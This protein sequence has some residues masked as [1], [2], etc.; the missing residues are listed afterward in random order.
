MVISD[1]S[2]LYFICLRRFI[3][4]PYLWYFL[5][6]FFSAQFSI[7]CAD[8]TLIV[9]LFFQVLLF[10][11]PLSYPMYSPFYPLSVVE[12]FSMCQYPL[13]FS[14]FVTYLHGDSFYIQFYITVCLIFFCVHFFIPLLVLTYELVPSCISCGL[15]LPK[16]SP[17]IP[18]YTLY[19]L[20]IFKLCP[21]F[22]P[23]NF[24]YLIFRL[25]GSKQCK[26]FPMLSTICVLNL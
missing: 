2:I 14:F 3:Y 18:K 26:G 16:I 20:L 24:D 4:H 23:N 17:Y 7:N 22:C 5:L 19:L 9:S 11:S 10:D 13:C 15:L 12:I 6:L 25:Y 1:L 21:S 8:M